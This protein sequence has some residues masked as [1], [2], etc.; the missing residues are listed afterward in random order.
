MITILI[1]TFR[2]PDCCRRLIESIRKHY[3]N[4]KIIVAIDDDS[5]DNF[6]AEMLVLPF[7]TG[8]SAGRN[9]LVDKCETPYCVIIDDDCIFTENTNLDGVLQELKERD[10]DI[11]Q[12]DIPD[13][14]RGSG[15]FHGIY[16]VT[17]TINDNDTL[18]VKNE[19]RDGLYDYVANIFM[20]KTDSLRKCRW[21][22]ELKLGEHEAYFRR[23]KGKMKIGKTNIGSVL[24]RHE[25][26]TSEYG[27]MRNRAYQYLRDGLLADGFKYKVYTNGIKEAV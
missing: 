6:D 11:I 7:D 4:I 16:E 21:H 10:L 12:F 25:N 23:H 24:H 5:G 22:E 20:A 15:T 1:K 14:T 3:P 19:D 9:R 26:E 13:D 8:L 2:R 17:K 18:V 27:G